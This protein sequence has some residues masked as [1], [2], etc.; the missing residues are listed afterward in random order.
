MEAEGWRLG[1]DVWELGI[2]TVWLEAGVG[3]EDCSWGPRT[4][5]WAHFDTGISIVIC[6]KNYSY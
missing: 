3:T 4:E 6:D 2:G 1:A 5:G